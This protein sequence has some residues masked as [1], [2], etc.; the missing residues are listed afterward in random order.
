[1]TVF[2]N[3]VNDN[4]P[5]F[6]QPSYSAELPENMTAGTRV[7]QVHADDL[8]TG[9]GGKVRYTSIQGYLNTSLNLDAETG[10]ITV[11]T[12]NHGFDREQM[13]EYHFYVEARDDNGSGNVA[14]VPLIL[15]VSDVNDEMP[16][17]EKSLYEFVLTPDLRN[18]TSPAFIRAI[19]GDAEP[20]NNVV[21]YEIVQGNYDNKI[22]V[23][24]VTGQVTLRAPLLKMDPM[25]ANSMTEYSLR[26][27]AFD[28]GAPVQFSEATVRI[29][30]PESRARTIQFVVPNY[31]YNNPKKT[32]DV[33][34]EITGGKVTIVEV[35]PY[36]GQEHGTLVAEGSGREGK[37]RWILI[38]LMGMGT[39]N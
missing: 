20:P 38:W 15:K 35:K 18:F 30:P 26:V 9:A 19:D 34:A 1:M 2:I 24:E 36:T 21:R 6:S 27:R 28:L 14:Q 23:N 3:D 25:D 29:Y 39:F 22:K 11:S 31:D 10:L 13:A 32:E 5:V 16:I 37:E 8:D 4:P 33:L 17:F 7:V 12:D